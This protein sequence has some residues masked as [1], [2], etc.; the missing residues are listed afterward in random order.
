MDD[1]K[2]PVR[3]N[4]LAVWSMVILY[5]A[6]GFFWYAPFMFLDPY[7]KGRGITLEQMNSSL[8]DMNN[9]VTPFVYGI[10]GAVLAYYVVSW[11]ICRLDIRNI[12]GGITLGLFLFAGIVFHAIAPRYKFLAINDVVL[13]IDLGSAFFGI[14][15]PCGILAIWRKGK[16]STDSV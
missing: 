4:H 3:H 9:D 6:F 15:V 1:K 7:L 10:I 12:A 11:L 8:E 2:K 13:W 5:Q 14:I 16:V